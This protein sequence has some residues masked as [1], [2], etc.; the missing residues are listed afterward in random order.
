MSVCAMPYRSDGLLSVGAI[1]LNGR[2]ASVG[3]TRGGDCEG[4][5]KYAVQANAATISAATPKRLDRPV[6]GLAGGGVSNDG[7]DG[8]AEVSVTCATK[9]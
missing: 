8:G 9:R 5:T 4:R 6:P 7:E 2:I 1:V 3:A